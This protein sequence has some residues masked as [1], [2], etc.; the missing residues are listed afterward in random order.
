MK[1]IHLSILAAIIICI[2][3]SCTGAGTS[4]GCSSLGSH[5]MCFNDS[6]YPMPT[7]GFGNIGNNKYWMHLENAGCSA[8]PYYEYIVTDFMLFD[9]SSTN[10]PGVGTYQCVATIDTTN[11]AK[12][13]TFLMKYDYCSSGNWNNGS[14][15][16]TFTVGEFLLLHL[17]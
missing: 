8:I 11:M 6:V 4:S 13:F 15:H 17:K 7:Y 5:N 2:L 14:V 3:S 10:F 12:Q 16:T 1:R 9:G